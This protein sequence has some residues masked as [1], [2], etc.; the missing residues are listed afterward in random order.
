MQSDIIPSKKKV[1]I[2]QGQKNFLNLLEKGVADEDE[3][4][5]AVE[6]YVAD[7][8]EKCT[9]PQYYIQI[10]NFFGRAKKYREFLPED[11]DKVLSKL[12]LK[13]ITALNDGF[14]KFFAIYPKKEGR[15][16][17]KRF[18]NLICVKGIDKME[19]VIA[20]AQKYADA[21]LVKHTE[22]QYIMKA[23]NFLNI[24]KKPYRD[25]IIPQNTSF[26]NSI[27]V[28]PIIPSPVSEPINTTTPLPEIPFR[29]NNGEIVMDDDDF[30]EEEKESE[31]NDNKKEENNI[32]KNESNEKNEEDNDNV[33]NGE[34]Y[35]KLMNEEENE[36]NAE[37]N[38]EEFDDIVFDENFDM[39][40]L[41]DNY[42]NNED[43]DEEYDNINVSIDE[44]NQELPW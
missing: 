12:S 30:F 28:A 16:E 41:S 27:P 13:E 44:E 11:P 22:L 14:N 6:S 15:E 8:K 20:S 25:Y 18:F 19:D 10:Y 3:L 7:V 38:E 5:L 4:K 2:K 29:E 37:K 23:N 42:Q 32:E 17:A 26:T 1:A 34:N 39:R 9:A 24:E 31:S 43:Y 21:C 36:E 40:R 35:K 33:E